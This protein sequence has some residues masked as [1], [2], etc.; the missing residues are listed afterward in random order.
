MA[1]QNVSRTHTHAHNT[2]AHTHTFTH[3]LSHTHTHTHTVTHMCL[4]TQQLGRK[5]EIIR[6]T[7]KQTNKTE[8]RKTDN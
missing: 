2:H 1:V 3:T 4:H 6:Q 5:N 7:K 8:Q